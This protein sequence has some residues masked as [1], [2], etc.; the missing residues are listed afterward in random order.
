MGAGDP[1]F[2]PQLRMWALAIRCGLSPLRGGRQ[3][4]T[5]NM[6]MSS[7]DPLPTEGQR[8]RLGELLHKAFLEIRVLG[9]EGKP[10]QAADLA[11][12]FHNLPVEM[13]GWGAFSWDV[14]RGDLRHYEQKYGGVRGFASDYTTLLD[15]I[16]AD[17]QAPDAERPKSR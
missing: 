1:R 14:L 7:S 17:K 11:D 10:E 4:S 12:A 16:R 6:A 13:Y 3:N 2:Y 8:K 9:W 5:L 15:E